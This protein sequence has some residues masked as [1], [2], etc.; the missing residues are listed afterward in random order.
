[1]GSRTCRTAA[2]LCRLS[3]QT[4]TQV[5]V[6]LKSDQYATITAQRD[7]DASWKPRGRCKNQPTWY[8]L[9]VHQAHD[10]PV[11]DAAPPAEGFEELHLLLVDDVLHGVGVLPQLREG[12]ALSGERI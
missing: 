9:A 12:V 6:I 10:L 2:T 11:Q 8:R 1:M 5:I 4:D 7:F 3:Q